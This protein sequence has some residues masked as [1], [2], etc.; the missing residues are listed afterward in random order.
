MSPR[1]T[2]AWISLV[3]TLAV[4]G[5]Y[6]LALGRALASG[7]IDGERFVGLFASCVVVIVVLQV[8][9][10]IATAALTGRH[11][12]AP[13]DER[14]RLVELKATR[15]AYCVLIVLAM[16]V[17]L[18]SPALAGSSPFLFPRDPL[19]DATLVMSNG[20]LLSVVLAEVVRTGG[21]IAYYRLARA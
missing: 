13:A 2:S 8:V 17:C 16:T 3:T 1:E 11:G 10:A 6:F 7:P 21:Q 9:I 5:Y 19:G 12:E 18:L 14:E 20:V 15:I 4:W